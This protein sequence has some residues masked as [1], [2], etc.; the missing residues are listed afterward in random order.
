MDPVQLGHAIRA[1]RRH[2]L[3]TQTDLAEHAGVS[4]AAVWRLERGG[5]RSLTLRTA[6]RIAEALDALASLRLY[7]HG[8]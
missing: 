4:Q 8:E 5:V 3:W 6:D 7:W 2:H 1:V